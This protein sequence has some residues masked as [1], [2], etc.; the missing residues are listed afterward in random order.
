MAMLTV[1]TSD[2]AVELPA[3]VSISLGSEIIWS[4]NTGRISTGKM[5]GDVVAEKEKVTI[6]WQNLLKEE[7]DLIK[8]SLKAGFWPLIINVDGEPYQISAYRGTL[9][10]VPMGQL[11][12]GKYYYKTVSTEIVEQ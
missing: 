9:T 5:V 2:G 1:V 10:R 4:S 6:S 12:D 8:E 7:Y 3:P 11:G